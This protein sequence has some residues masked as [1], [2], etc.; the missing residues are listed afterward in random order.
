LRAQ[1]EATQGNH[2]YLSTREDQEF[3]AIPGYMMSW[4]P[5]SPTQVPVSIKL[6]R[7]K[8]KKG[9]GCPCSC[10]E[11]LTQKLAASACELGEGT[12]KRWDGDS[13]EWEKP[14][15]RSGTGQALAKKRRSRPTFSSV[16]SEALGGPN[17]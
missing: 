6:N 1:V 11:G 14:P 10:L 4:R 13:R 12:V 2:A 8:K 17:A 9:R 16:L 7:K 15:P 5:A 3:K